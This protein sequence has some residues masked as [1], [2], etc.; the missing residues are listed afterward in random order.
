VKVS[1]V[2]GV[3][4]DSLPKLKESGLKVADGP[5][6]V[7]DS[8]TVPIVPTLSVPSRPP[9][10]V[11]AKAT[12]I[13]QV[14]WA[15]RLARQVLLGCVKLAV[16]LIVP[17]VSEVAPPFETVTG[18]V[19]LV[20]PTCSL[21]KDRLDGDRPVVDPAV[22]VTEFDGAEAGPVPAALVA[23][24]VKVYAVP[25]ASPV[26]VIGL[27]EPLPVTPPGEDVTV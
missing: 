18:C 16:V 6:P 13:V 8:D 5:T 12:E 4:R 22:G 23:V 21:P 19:P 11:G 26:T 9:V 2:L 7:P 25:F 1:P 20:V 17:I 27:L 15:A 3:P 14:E 24:T 10:A